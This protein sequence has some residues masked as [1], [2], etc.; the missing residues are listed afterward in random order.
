MNNYQD[1]LDGIYYSNLN[2]IKK[3]INKD[4]I[5]IA[6]PDPQS[7]YPIHAVFETGSL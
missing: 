5:N 4:N 1:F 6:P 3:Y 2:K 7:M